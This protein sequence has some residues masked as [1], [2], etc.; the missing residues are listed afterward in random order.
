MEKQF[1]HGTSVENCFRW[2]ARKYGH[3]YKNCRKSGLFS[4][5]QYGQAGF[6]KA[7]VEDKLQIYFAISKGSP[8]IKK[9]VSHY[10]GQFFQ[11]L[12]YY[13]I[14]QRF[15]QKSASVGYKR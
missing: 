12:P 14:V 9:I 5:A 8:R 3:N 1:A 13:A 7:G 4:F 15:L 11:K 10:K 6:V 2:L